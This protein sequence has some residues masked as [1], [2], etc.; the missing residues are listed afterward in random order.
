MLGK[1][2]TPFQ[3]CHRVRELQLWVNLGVWLYM[4][5]C[6]HACGAQRSTLGV[7]PQE[8]SS[9]LF[10][11]SQDLFYLFYMYVCGSECTYVCDLSICTCMGLSVCMYVGLSCVCVWLQ[12]YVCACVCTLRKPQ[13]STIRY[14]E[15]R[16]GIEFP[17]MCYRWFVSPLII[18]IRN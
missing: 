17:G 8:L 1:A 13:R 10:F 7:V 14:L 4:Q 6:A 15:D 11:S 18:G 2:N 5:I 9:L 3:G 12:V 16:E